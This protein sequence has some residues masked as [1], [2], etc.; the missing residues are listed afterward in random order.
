MKYCTAI[1]V[2]V[3]VASPILAWGP[4]AQTTQAAESSVPGPEVASPPEEVPAVG[5]VSLWGRVRSDILQGWSESFWM[6]NWPVGWTLFLVAIFLGLVAGRICAAVLARLAARFDRGG[7]AIRA[8]VLNDLIGPA[9][10]A[11]LTLGLSFGLGLLDGMGQTLETI[12]V[13]TLLLL[14][15]IAVFWYA[16]NLVSVV[17]LMLLRLTAKTESTLDDQLVPLLRKALRIFL[18]VVG[19]LFVIDSVFQQD[20]GALVAAMAI[21]VLPIALS[22]Q[23][24]IKNLLG[25]ITILFDRPFQIGQRIVYAGYTGTVEEIGFRSTKLRTSTGHVVTI[26][27]AA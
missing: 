17:E 19:V 21:A 27:A 5:D 7:W 20:V 4:L 18:A 10:L 13:K 14:F 22:A 1:A 16:F 8:D 12:C 15:T 24:S 2:A 26:P 6:D 25:S 9:K 23:D 3:I 11:L